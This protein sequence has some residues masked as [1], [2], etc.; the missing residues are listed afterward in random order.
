[1][2]PRGIGIDTGGISEIHLSRY[3]WAILGMN[4]TT[5][6]LLIPAY[7]IVKSKFVLSFSLCYHFMRT[8]KVSFQN[9]YYKLNRSSNLGI[10]KQKNACRSLP[11]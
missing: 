9:R 6:L 3:Y 8:L 11:R 2:G 10:H 1:M 7:C 4:T 5:G